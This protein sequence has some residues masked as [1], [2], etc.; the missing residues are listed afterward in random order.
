MNDHESALQSQRDHNDA[1][2]VAEAAY[3]RGYQHGA[4]YA[5]QLGRQG[6]SVSSIEE[7]ANSTVSDWRYLKPLIPRVDAPDAGKRK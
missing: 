6:M 2:A 3:R 7:Y 5:A 4:A 1:D